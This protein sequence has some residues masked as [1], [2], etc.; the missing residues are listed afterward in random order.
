MKDRYWFEHDSNAHTDP[1]ITHLRMKYGLAAYGAYWVIVEKLRDSGDYTIDLSLLD[2]ICFDLRIELEWVDLMFEIGLLECDDKRFWSRT[3]L[4]RMSKWDEAKAKRAAA[5]RKGGNAKAM[6]KQCQDNAKAMPEQCQSNA[7]AST[8][9]YSTVHNITEEDS[10]DVDS[11]LESVQKTKTKSKRK[12]ALPASWEPNETHV[13]IAEEL[14]V[15][16]STQENAFRDYEAAHRRLM[17]DW[18][19]AFRMWLKKSSEFRAKSRSSPQPRTTQYQRDMDFLK[20]EMEKE[21]GTRK[22]NG[23]GNNSYGSGINVRSLPGKG[24]D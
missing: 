18:D 5:G 6:L 24:F 16:L 22:E 19:A 4:D 11:A 10:R 21:I 7:L 2:A 15:C 1:K 9:H 8:L 17:V 3:L 20:R 13:R 12:T 23:Q 14:G